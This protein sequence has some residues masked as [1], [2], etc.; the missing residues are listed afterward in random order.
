MV[1][2]MLLLHPCI[3]GADDSADCDSRTVNLHRLTSTLNGPSV[4][5]ETNRTQDKGSH[6]TKRDSTLQD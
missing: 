4:V 1:V 2:F 3:D 5:V 6:D